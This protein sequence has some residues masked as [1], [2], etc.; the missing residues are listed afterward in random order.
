MKALILDPSKLYRQILSDVL[1][2]LGYECLAADNL[3]QGRELIEQHLCALLCVSLHLP[4]GTGIEFT[5]DFR[6]RYPT[7]HAPIL[8][9]TSE[10]DQ[11]LLNE[12][13]SVGVT[14]LFSKTDLARLSEE[15]TYFVERQRRSDFQGMVIVYIEDDA[16]TARLTCGILEDMRLDIRHFESAEEAIEFIRSGGCDLVLSDVL[17]AGAMS[18]RALVRAVRELAGDD[19]QLPILAITAHDDLARRIELFRAGVNDYVVKPVSPEELKARVANLLA[20]RHL[21]LRVKEH[22]R[23]LYEQ[24]MSD[25]LTGCHNRHSL[26]EFAPKY[27]ADAR[28]HDHEL[29]LLMVD[30]DHFKKIND[31]QGHAVGDIVLAETGALL[32]AQCRESDFVARFGGEEFVLLLA[33]CPAEHALAKAEALRVAIEQLT[34]HGLA[35]SA[36]IGVA[37]LAPQMEDF[38]ALFECADAAVYAAKESGRN[39]VIVGR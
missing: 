8:M 23:R 30:L 29:A 25:R 22:E 32:R 31:T 20:T 1:A 12:A 15:L 27:F 19:A 3:A 21:F 28:R 2:R 34:P 13:L 10:M 7:R 4:D 14:E 5:R 33:H 18:G 36:S 11:K 6:A 35:I 39:C 16:A 38:Q 26:A 37:M 17:L 9:L 24:A